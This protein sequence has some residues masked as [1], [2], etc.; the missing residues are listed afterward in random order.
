MQIKK[1]GC[2]TPYLSLWLMM[3]HPPSFFTP[4][5]HYLFASR[6]KEMIIT[7]QFTTDQTPSVMRG[8][9]IKRTMRVGMSPRR[10]RT[11]HPMM[12]SSIEMYM[13][14]FHSSQVL[15]CFIICVVYVLFITER[16]ILRVKHVRL[17]Q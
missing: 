5:L 4:F 3:T 16:G 17:V 2:V 15:L 13:V 14:V 10:V 12:I 1:R 11:N 6:K 8:E 7:T 9:P